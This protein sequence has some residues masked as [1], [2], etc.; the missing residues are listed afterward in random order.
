DLLIDGD[1]FFTRLRQAIEAA[2]NHIDMNLFI[3]D[4]DDV[5]V[6]F[7]DQLKQRSSAVKTRIVLDRMGTLAAGISPP[8]TPLPENFVPPKSL[9]SYLK[10][11]SKVHVRSFL[12]PWFSADHCKVIVIDGNEAWLG[13]MNIGREY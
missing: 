3:F 9:F 7:A 1:R 12:N 8:A 5:A 6:D 13:G 2:T 11:D 4:R 10:E